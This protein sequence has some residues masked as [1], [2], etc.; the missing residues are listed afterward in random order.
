MVKGHLHAEESQIVSI[1]GMAGFLP[2]VLPA[3]SPHPSPSSSSAPR[4]KS[5]H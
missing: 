4:P 3:A 2:G 5:S 1:I